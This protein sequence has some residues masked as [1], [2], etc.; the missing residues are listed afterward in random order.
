MN[1]YKVSRQP[2]SL[3]ENQFYLCVDYT[4]CSI[5][6]LMQCYL[7]TVKYLFQS[8]FPNSI[9]FIPET[10]LHVSASLQ[11][12]LIFCVFLGDMRNLLASFL[13]TFINHFLGQNTSVEFL[14]ML[15]NQY[16][17]LLTLLAS[18][19][20]FWNLSAFSEFVLVFWEHFPYPR[21]IIP[22]SFIYSSSKYLLSDY[23]VPVTRVTKVNKTRSLP[24]LLMLLSFCFNCSLS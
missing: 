1:K 22:Y 16:F 9:K 21:P 12:I 4:R 19:P 20:E 11:Y 3:E 17:H 7:I 14:C 6:C 10:I 18:I 23:C 5:A 13:I 15:M 2:C 24:F 8:S